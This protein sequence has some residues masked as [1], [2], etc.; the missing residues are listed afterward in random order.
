[1]CACSLLM[2]KQIYLFPFRPRYK[3]NSFGIHSISLPTN[4]SSFATYSCAG[5]AAWRATSLTT[6]L[7]IVLSTAV[8]MTSSIGIYRIQ[9]ISHSF[10]TTKTSA[11]L[12]GA[13]K[14]DA[15]CTD[16]EFADDIKLPCSPRCTTFSLD[17]WGRGVGA[18]FPYQLCRRASIHVCL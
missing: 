5:S 8:G 13:P 14:G 16:F 6:S 11:N 17:L 9:V 3:Q 1:M 18:R 7:H 2:F 4:S 12:L 15:F 10:L